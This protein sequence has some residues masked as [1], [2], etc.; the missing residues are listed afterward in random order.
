[1][2][3]VHCFDALGASRA[4]A[5]WEPDSAG[6]EADSFAVAPKLTGASA[7]GALSSAP[8]A[9]GSPHSSVAGAA[10]AV[11]ATRP[12]LISSAV[13]WRTTPVL[14]HWSAPTRI[15]LMTQPDC[16]SGALAMTCLVC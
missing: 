13:A 3:L 15:S 16:P 14:I 12:L 7:T 1:M 4:W 8:S 11:S 10:G 6:S 5:L 9:S 2:H